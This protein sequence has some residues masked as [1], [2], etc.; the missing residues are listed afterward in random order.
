M[1]ICNIVGRVTKAAMDKSKTGKAFARLRVEQ[2]KPGTDRDGNAR[3][4]TTRFD[5]SVYGLDATS[6]AALQPGTW[7]W[8]SGEV[9]AKVDEW[10]G[11]TYAKLQ[12]IGR[13]GVLDA[14]NFEEHKQQYE[15]QSAPPRA[16]AP[17]AAPAPDTDG[18]PPEEDD[19]PF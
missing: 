4:F 10:K 2:S 12:L 19:V 13:V 3:N 14:G 16:A 15:R 11:E 9:S 1:N 18:P 7:V 17:Q 5:V 8:A 6:V